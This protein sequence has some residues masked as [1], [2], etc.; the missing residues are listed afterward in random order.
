MRYTCRHA[1][2]EKGR[3]VA[4]LAGRHTASAAQQV[5]I[6]AGHRHG[7]HKWSS[8]P[9]LPPP[10]P[11]FSPPHDVGLQAAE[12]LAGA[13]QG[14]HNGA[15]ACRHGWVGGWV[16]R[17][18]PAGGGRVQVHAVSHTRQCMTPE[19]IDVHP[20]QCRWAQATHPPPSG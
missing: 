14:G 12:N 20:H 3:S 10:F 5:H 9:P 19:A 17:G 16:Q 8:G 1:V 13:D 11:P 18:G 2:N 7:L 15:N 6:P 4:Q